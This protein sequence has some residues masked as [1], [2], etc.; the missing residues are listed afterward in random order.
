MANDI[1]IFGIILSIIFYEITEISPG[2]LIVPAYIAFYINT[3][4]RIIIT[5]IAGILTFLIVK[6]ISNHTII[7]GRRKFAL[8]IM[9]SFMIR[10]IL[11][12]FNIY[13]VNEYEIY[14]LGG[15]VIGVIIPGI[16]A[17]EM[18]RH[19]IIRTVSSLMILSIFIKA[20]V[21]VIYKAGGVN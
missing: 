8:C 10:L 20:V 17:Q 6:F 11:K 19:G 2:G 16:M 15:S 3:P 7:Y 14:I 5:I 13:I 21:E 18:D 9:I 12:Y 1:I 4:Q